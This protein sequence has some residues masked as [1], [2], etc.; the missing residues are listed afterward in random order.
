MSM[1]NDIGKIVEIV[2]F[3]DIGN[4]DD[5]KDIL[6]PVFEYEYDEHTSLE[7]MQEIKTN[8]Q[9]IHSYIYTLVTLSQELPL[10]NLYHINQS[11]IDLCLTYGD[12]LFFNNRCFTFLTERTFNDISTCT[13]AYLYNNNLIKDNIKELSLENIGYDIFSELSYAI[14]LFMIKKEEIKKDLLEFISIIGINFYKS[15]WQRIYE[16]VVNDKY[17]ADK[18]NCLYEQFTIQCFSYPALS[19]TQI[20]KLLESF[21]K[22][23]YIH[24]IFIDFLKMNNS[25]YVDKYQSLLLM[26]Q[27]K[28]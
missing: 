18:L 22:K 5:Y 11:L 2:S 21:Y 10:L 20:E 28:Q 1:Y 26:E 16:L 7:K 6:I 25:S 4:S 27:I 13:F 19:I 14:E 24:Y 12:E 3:F 9:L 23:G 17:P 15:Y 8:G